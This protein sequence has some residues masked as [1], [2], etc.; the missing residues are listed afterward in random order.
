MATDGHDHYT[1]N[2]VKAILAALSPA[3]M[4]RLRRLAQVQA[5]KIPNADPYELLSEGLTRTLDGR[6]KW[7][8]G[9]EPGVFFKNVFASIVSAAAKHQVHASQFE[10]SMEVDRSGDVDPAAANSDR[11]PRDSTMDA[12]YATEM[13]QKVVTILSSDQKALAVAMALG[14]GL[15]AKEAQIQFNMKPNEYDAARKR[16]YR[17]VTRLSAEEGEP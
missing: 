15:T 17:A 10:T 5:A 3:D 8:R 7:P 13:L 9:L 1:L 14:E 11:A 2:E 16:V 4:V 6:R 12:V